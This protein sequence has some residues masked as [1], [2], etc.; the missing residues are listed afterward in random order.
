MKAERAVIAVFTG[1]GNTLIAANALA[2]ALRSAGKGVALIP[3]HRAGGAEALAAAGF[4][5]GS[6]LGIAAPVAAFSTY[7]TVWRF[8][9]SLPAGEGREAFF[10]ATMGGSGFGMQGPVARVLRRKGYAPI[11]AA[12]IRMCGNYGGGVPTPEAFAPVR[13]RAEEKA[14]AYC[15][16]L[17]AGRTRWGCG[18]LNILA[19][20]FAW[21]ARTGKASRM[22]RRVFP[23]SVDGAKCTGCGLC[24]RQCPERAITMAEGGKAV[25]D[26]GACQSCQRCIAYCP[27]RAVGVPGKD[28]RQHRAVSAEAMTE[29]LA[30][31][32]LSN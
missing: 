12:L 19:P 23:L 17:L 5:S 20:L 9:E 30:A 22:F 14:A 21:T 18:R 6:A 26:G 3:A 15:E 1:T 29:F 28:M 7:P 13:A 24:A 8:I 4:D 31:E 2:D 16:R 32:P 25:L 10:L 11:G 27:A